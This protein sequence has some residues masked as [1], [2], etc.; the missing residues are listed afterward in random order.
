MGDLSQLVENIFMRKF[1]PEGSQGVWEVESKIIT[2]ISVGIL[3][4]EHSE[5]SFMRYMT[6]L[7]S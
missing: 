5:I 2:I 4:C 7:R 3:C 6:K 1:S